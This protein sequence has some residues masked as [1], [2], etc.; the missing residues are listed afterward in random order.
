MTAQ[1][2]SHVKNN[3]KIFQVISPVLVGDVF[4]TKLFIDAPKL[5]H[6]FSKSREE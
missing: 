5:Q 1:Q 4:Y 3:W 2:V 6:M